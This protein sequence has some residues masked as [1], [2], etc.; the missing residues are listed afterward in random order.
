MAARE[1]DISKR[2]IYRYSPYLSS[3][4]GDEQQGA[5]PRTKLEQMDAKFCKR[6]EQTLSKDKPD[7]TE[8]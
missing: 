5:W 8:R 6:L 4:V 2:K 3:Q 1:T 7:Q